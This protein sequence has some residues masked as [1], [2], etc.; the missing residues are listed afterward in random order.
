MRENYQALSVLIVDDDALVRTVIQRMLAEIGVGDVHVAGTAELALEITAR[1]QNRLD[2]VIS[3]LEMPGVDGLEFLRR[4]SDLH[5]RAAVLI[6]S[7][8]APDILRSVDLM[9][10]EYGLRVLGVLAKPT[11]LAAL[12]EM[13]DRASAADPGLVRRT[14]H[15]LPLEDV[16]RAVE[17]RELTLLYQPRVAL[18]TE[19]VVGAE[20]L[21]RWRH[22]SSGLILPTRF[23]DTV[24]TLGLMDRL[25][26][27]VLDEAA[28]DLRRWLDGGLDL[29]V[30]VNVSQSC[31]TGNAF[32]ARVLE[33]CA[34]RNVP[35]GRLTI[36]ITE[37]VAMTDLAPALETL[38]RL[39]MH[40]VGLAIDD[41]GTGHSS[42][43]QLSRVPFTELKIDRG[44]V[45]GAAREPFLRTIVES[46]VRMAR[47][48][49]LACAGEGIETR[50]DWDVLRAVGCDF[51]QGYFIAGPMEGAQLPGW[52]R[53]WRGTKER[54]G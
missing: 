5:P 45:T 21:V 36:E 1:L 43:Q 54:I 27:D 11:T 48:L 33:V 37:T 42:L 44:F 53:T 46:N 41:F 14:G 23:L 32:S 38:A 26:L 28:T 10:R 18:A 22:P 40:G 30:S 19:Q 3:D 50:E 2:V 25:T 24:E 29:S 49:G 12:R 16:R 4:L 39:R 35:P 52:I 31:L 7:G 13:L 8:K 47:T 34:R 17:Q 15:T 6:F 51:G 9:A 20:A